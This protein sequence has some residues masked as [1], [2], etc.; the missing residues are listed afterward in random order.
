MPNEFVKQAQSA[1]EHV[2]SAAGA[3]PVPSPPILPVRAVPG[4]YRYLIPLSVKI[5][6]V[7][8]MLKKGSSGDSFEFKPDHLKVVL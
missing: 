8:K 5:H 3:R 6:R 4:R 7:K 2:L 1:A